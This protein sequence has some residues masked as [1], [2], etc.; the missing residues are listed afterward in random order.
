V[1]LEL[2]WRARRYEAAPGWR[3]RALIV[4]LAVFGV[5][6]VA[7]RLW[8]AALPQWSLAD[9]AALGTWGGAAAGILLY[10][11][12]HY[13]YHRAAFLAVA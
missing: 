11:L 4:S 8:S 7:G 9:G 2:A 13:W 1:L 6:L 10:E 12:A 3:L 5:S